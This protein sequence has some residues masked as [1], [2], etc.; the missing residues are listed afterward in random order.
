M[1]A[2]GLLLENP[3]FDSYNRKVARVNTKLQPTDAEYRPPIDFEV[4]RNEMEKFKEEF[5]CS[6]MRNVEDRDGM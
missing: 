1:P 6:N 5:I 3:I 4:H 2:L